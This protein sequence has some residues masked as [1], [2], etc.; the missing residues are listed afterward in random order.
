[1]SF[2]GDTLLIAQAIFFN[3]KGFFFGLLLFC[4]V[5]PTAF[6][7]LFPNTISQSVAHS[8]NLAQDEHYFAEMRNG[9]APNFWA[10]GGT[11]G[12]MIYLGKRLSR[13]SSRT[14]GLRRKCTM[15]IPCPR[16]LNRIC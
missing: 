4:T 1:M 6:F 3:E 16:N 12:D 2:V 11:Y 9:G 8:I 15:P 14:V 10:Y 7:L 5:G 13:Q